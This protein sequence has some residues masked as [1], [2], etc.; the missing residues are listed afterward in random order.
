MT[1]SAV[2]YDDPRTD[3]GVVEYSISINKEIDGEPLFR[4]DSNNGKLFVMV[5]INTTHSG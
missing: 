4:I 3:N 1:V 2:D 5:N